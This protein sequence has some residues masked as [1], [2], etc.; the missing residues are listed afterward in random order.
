MFEDDP[1]FM[2]DYNAP[3]NL[4]EQFRALQNLGSKAVNFVGG[5]V[6]MVPGFLGQLRQDIKTEAQAPLKPKTPAVASPVVS[7][8][9]STLGLAETQAKTE[10]P[11]QNIPKTPKPK[12]K[13]K[14]EEPKTV[15][16]PKKPT[17]RYGGKRKPPPSVTEKGI[18]QLVNIR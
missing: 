13:T 9:Q 14:P 18:G 15:N 12:A 10:A 2:P 16:R 4:G 7:G 1:G 17:P 3:I 5:A 6:R 8:V 11:R